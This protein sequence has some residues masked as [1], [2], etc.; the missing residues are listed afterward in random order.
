LKNFY[1]VAWKL[2]LI[3]FVVGLALLI[4][5]LWLPKSIMGQ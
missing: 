1:Q 3:L 4:V 2:L 5:G